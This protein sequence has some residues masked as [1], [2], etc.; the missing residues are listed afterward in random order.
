[1]QHFIYEARDKNGVTR[2]GLVEAD[3]ED[4]VAILLRANGLTLVSLR[5][6]IEVE[7]MLAGFFRGLIYRI[8][9]KDKTLFARQLATMI[10]A[11]LP[12]M[13]SLRLL[14]TQTKN[15]GMAAVLGRIVKDIEGGKSFGI[16][17]GNHPNVFSSVFISMVKSGE[18]SGRLDSVLSEIA[19]QQEK[20]L[21]LSGKF[22]S[23]MVYPLF[24]ASAMGGVGVLMI[25]FVIPKLVPLFQEAQIKLPILTRILIFISGFMINYWFLVIA[26]IIILAVAI[27]MLLSLPIG[28]SVFDRLMLSLPVFGGINQKVI[29]SR[30]ARTFSLLISGGVPILEALNMV[31]EATGNVVYEKVIKGFSAYV[32]KGIPLSKPMKTKPNLF[33]ALAADMVSVGEQTGQLDS[34]LLSIGKTYEREADVAIRSISSLIEPL[35]M[36]ILGI[37]VAFIVFAVLMPVFQITQSA[38]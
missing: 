10:G 26:F 12:L 7:E 31:S 34:T 37:G 35:I 1:M 20:D 9:N 18:A 30:F 29:I 33:P 24:I 23:A 8:T 28:R 14:Q 16:A 13:Q 32:E 38:F 5:P 4:S 15:K 27:K 11:G 19:D 6:K 2:R 36:M 21:E 22:R 25:V 3:N 17:V